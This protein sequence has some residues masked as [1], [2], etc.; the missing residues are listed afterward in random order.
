MNQSEV[1]YDG[2]GSHRHFVQ[3]YKADEPA[4]NRNVSGFLWD[5]LLRGD[6]LLVIAT[7]QRRESLSSH[8]ARLG[9][10][11]ALARR[12]GQLAMLD[13]AEMLSRFMVDGQPHPERFQAAVDEALQFA[14]PRAA[15]AG[16]CAYGEMV[17]ILWEAGQTTAAIRLEEFWNQL[18][19]EGGISLFCGYPIDIFADSF[20]R[21]HI[22]DVLCAHT[23]VLPTGG[24]G[25]LGAALDR[26]MDEL[27]GT[28]ADEVR[29][30]MNAGLPASNLAMPAAE[31]AILW[32][33]SHVPE[34]AETIL[35]RARNYYEARAQ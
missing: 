29:S 11:V 20:E 32:L 3:F 12:E 27:L 14:R 34:N 10:D 31:S 21:T 22:H 18:L 26:A 30:S 33:R 25:D 2:A 1:V 23:H 6:G 35:A 13:A 4:L 7:A 9:A 5:G 28:A 17:G 8:L 15:E 16:I 19:R 24:D